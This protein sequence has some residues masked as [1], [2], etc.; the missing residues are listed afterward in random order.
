MAMFNEENYAKKTVNLGVSDMDQPQ[1]PFL[2]VVPCISQ[3]SSLDGLGGCL[4]TSDGFMG[5]GQNINGC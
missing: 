5:S 4:I 2:D 1:F 3:Q